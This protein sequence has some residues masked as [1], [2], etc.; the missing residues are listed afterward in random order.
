MTLAGYA[1]YQCSNKLFCFKVCALIAYICVEVEVYDCAKAATMEFFKFISL[2]C[3]F[4][5]LLLWAFLLFKL[6]VRL[7]RCEC[8]N[9]VFIVSERREWTK[10]GRV[11]LVRV[12]R[13][14]RKWSST[15]SFLCFSSSATYFWACTRV[16]EDRRL[17]L[18]VTSFTISLNVIP[19][20]ENSF[21]LFLF[22][23]SSS[24]G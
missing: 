9:W 1:P 13:F 17:E 21:E 18:W 19:Y 4:L 22:G 7:L 20:R 14:Y 8:V 2:G 11:V 16:E 12:Y 5:A 6:E 3:F 10:Y 24:G 23:F 15:S